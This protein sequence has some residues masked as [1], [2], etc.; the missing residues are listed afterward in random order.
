[1]S[2]CLCF[3]DQQLID[4]KNTAEAYSKVSH[5]FEFLCQRLWRKKEASQWNQMPYCSPVAFYC[6]L[7]LGILQGSLYKCKTVRG[8]LCL[9][10]FLKSF[11]K[12]SCFPP[13][14]FNIRPHVPWDL[15]GLNSHCKLT[16]VPWCQTVILETEA[17]LKAGLW[18]LNIP[19]LLWGGSKTA[20]RPRL[21]LPGVRIRVS[22]A[23]SKVVGPSVHWL[24]QCHA[25]CS[26][27]HTHSLIW[28][29][30]LPS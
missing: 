30:Q 16:F 4:R 1:M 15:R 19:C 22:R 11:L 24:S 25:L 27:L 26:M 3:Q 7:E 18:P 9:L 12:M 6:R 17:G 20:E 5:W 28:F 21:T 8:S 2:P 14:C 10:P 13:L 23:S 29:S